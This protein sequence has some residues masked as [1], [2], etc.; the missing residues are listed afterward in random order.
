GDIGEGALI[1]MRPVVE[2]QDDI[3]TA[4][5][6]DGGGN[7]RLEVVRVDGLERDL[8]P[9]LLI[10]F[11]D[12]APQFDVPLGNEIDPLKKVDLGPLSVGGRPAGREDLFDPTGGDGHTDGTTDP[13]EG[14]AID[15]GVLC[16]I[17]VCWI[18]VN[19]LSIF[20]LYA[21]YFS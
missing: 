17:D 10:V 4:A 16:L 21:R 11:G 7:A 8:G 20:P 2:H 9:R 6:L 15:T 5:G 19:R 1:E 18:H 3:G 13:E 14:P 12:L